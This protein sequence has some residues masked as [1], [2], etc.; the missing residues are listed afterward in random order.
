M[1]ADCF[2]NAFGVFLPGQAVTNDRVEDFLGM[3]HGKPS[4]LAKR[5]LKTNGIKLRHYAIDANQKTVF[6]NSEMAALAVKSC[7]EAGKLALNSIDYLAVATSQGDLGLPGM[8]SLVQGEL[9]IPSCEI[10]TTVSICSAGIPS[11]KAAC[12]EIRLTEK[13]NAMVCASDLSSR[14]LK[15]QRYENSAVQ[16]DTEAEFLRWMLSDGAGAALLQGHPN[17]SG[18]SLRIDFIDMLSYAGQEPLCMYVGTKDGDAWAHHSGGPKK[19][20]WLDYDSFE[21]AEK[22][23]ALLLRQNLRLLDRMIE[24]GVEGFV[25]LERQGRISADEIDYVVCHYSA[26]PFR[27]KIMKE[28]KKREINVSEDSWFSNLE[29]KGNTGCA[30]IFISL[31]ELFYSG[32][33]KPDDVIFCIV[34]ES[35]RFNT[36]HVKLTVVSAA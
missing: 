35:G 13:K 1:V 33:L 29:T 6:Q 24:L 12:N 28:L 27:T 14:L 2:I 5:V 17:E 20:S 7:A 15:S 19:I 8:A 34:P 16:P 9:A 32:R 18:I 25:R 36:C 30:A 3:V 21:E 31:E 23:G 10:I 26:E 4:K 11:L 22:D